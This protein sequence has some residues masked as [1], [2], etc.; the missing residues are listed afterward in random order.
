MKPSLL[1]MAA[2]M[3]SRYGSLKQ[4]DHFGPSGET[5]M[6][7]S[8]YD[9]LRAGFGKVVFIIRESFAEEFEQLII[10]KI[11]P[12]I[13]VEWVFQE[14]DK[15]PQGFL[16]PE[17][18]TKPWGTAHAALMAK[19]SI[20]E[21][22]AVINGDDFYGSTAFQT[23]AGFLNG[24]TA[25][26]TLYALIGYPLGAT[27]SS[28]G[29][30][31]R[32]ICEHDT[33]NL[34]TKITE[35]TNIR[36]EEGEIIFTDEHG[37]SQVVA[38]NTPVSMNFWGFSPAW[39]K[40]TENIFIEFLKDHGN[41]LSSEFYIPFVVDQLIQQKTATVEVLK[42]QAKWFGVTYKED[43]PQVKQQ[44]QMLIDTGHYPPELW[45]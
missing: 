13:Q 40:Q 19:D 29:S 34:L 11:K 31:S 3:G 9:A 8:I 15:L 12:F 37:Q 6:D 43:K 22:F 45:R 27:V 30:V 2:G 41:S 14:T 44:L 17:G 7:Y 42:T 39:F 32:G 5:I 21:P 16:C 35:R 20:Q 1:I 33:Q 36:Y 38:A 24:I 23:M 28:F 10:K 25:T 4:L 26:D 18:R